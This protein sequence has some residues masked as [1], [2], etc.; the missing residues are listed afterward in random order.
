MLDRK[1]DLERPTGAALESGHGQRVRAAADGCV[2]S[3]H[4]CCAGR[5]AVLVLVLVPVGPR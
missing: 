2:K 1:A 4:K 3:Y 5:L